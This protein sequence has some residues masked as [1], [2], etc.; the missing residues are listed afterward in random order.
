MKRW[1]S[2]EIDLLGTD[3]DKRVA[4]RLG[5]TEN[6]VCVQR[7]IRRIPPHEA[8]PLLRSEKHRAMLGRV[9]DQQIADELGVLR[10]AVQ[11]TRQ[12]LG[13]PAY[14]PQRPRRESHD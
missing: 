11:Y 5:R 7:H 9:P 8:R 10:Q 3:T 1:Q 13:I 4:E 12:A 6:A 14:R 2:W